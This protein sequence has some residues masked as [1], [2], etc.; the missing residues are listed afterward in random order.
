MLLE[1]PGNVQEDSGGSSKRLRGMFEKIAGDIGKDYGESLTIFQR[2]K[3]DSREH[4]EK[5]NK[6]FF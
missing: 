3:K 4:W 2:N 1:I 5:S 6:Q